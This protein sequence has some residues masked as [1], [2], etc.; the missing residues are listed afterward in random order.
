[1]MIYSGYTKLNKYENIPLK[2]IYQ[3]F[4]YKQY[5]EDKLTYCQVLYSISFL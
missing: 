1:M 4:I 3:C 2:F 5:I